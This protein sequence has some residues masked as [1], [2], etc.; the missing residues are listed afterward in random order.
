[1]GSEKKYKFLCFI[2]MLQRKNTFSFLKKQQTNQDSTLTP[3]NS[4]II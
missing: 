2:S 1:M 3:Y 4:K